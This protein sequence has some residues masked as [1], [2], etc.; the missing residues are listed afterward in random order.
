M[1][2][3]YAELS[4]VLAALRRFQ[5]EPY[6]ERNDML[7]FEDVDSL[8]DDVD[9]LTDDQIDSLCERLNCDYN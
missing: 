5:D 4:T 2:L 1:K 7:H 3:T 6:D 9:S 8:T